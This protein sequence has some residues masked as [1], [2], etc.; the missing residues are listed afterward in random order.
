MQE[1]QLS[2]KELIA[3]E[4][5][6]RTEQLN[7]E[8]ELIT[9][10]QTEIQAHIHNLENVIKHFKQM[11]KVE[12]DP[13]KRSRFHSV[14]SHNIELLAKLYSVYREF[15]DTKN[16]FYKE[17]NTLV[18]SKIRITNIELDKIQKEIDDTNIL[19][20]QLTESAFKSKNTNSIID[21]DEILKD[22]KYQI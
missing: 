10:R 16:K 1:E 2:Q 9:I 12:K 8:I 18:L 13:D 4:L 17:G 6:E 5:D 14:I 15:E 21:S 22:Q 7:R 19:L 11:L 3:K 20:A